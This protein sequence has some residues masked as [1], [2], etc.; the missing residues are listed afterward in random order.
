M[1]I[2][3]QFKPLQIVRSLRSLPAFCVALCLVAQCMVCIVTYSFLQIADNLLTVDCVLCSVPCCVLCC[4]VRS[5]C[6]CGSLCLVCALWL[7]VLRLCAVVWCCLAVVQAVVCCVLCCVLWCGSDLRSLLN[8]YGEPCLVRYMY[9]AV[10]AYSSCAYCALY[11]RML[12]SYTVILC[13]AI[14]VL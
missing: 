12:Y 2:V 10:I 7:C 6:C 5:V 1:C 8:R 4:G 9:H 11:G 14:A 3:A 13:V